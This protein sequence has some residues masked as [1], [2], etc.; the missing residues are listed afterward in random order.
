MVDVSSNFDHLRIK[1][2]ANPAQITV[3]FFF[4][5]R[6]NQ[7]FTVFRAEYDVEVIAYE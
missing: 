3:Q 6:V 2:G 4:N 5:R 7:S 1:I